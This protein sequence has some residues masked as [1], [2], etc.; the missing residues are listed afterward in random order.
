MTMQILAGEGLDKL[1][2]QR[3]E[4]P[5]SETVMAFLAQLSALLL[6]HPR[7]KAHPE[8]TALGFWLR[9]AHLSQLHSALPPL[10]SGLRKPLG[11][12]L[13]ITPAN[14]DSMFIYSWVCSLL[15]GNRNILRLSSQSSEVKDC[16]LDLLLELFEQSRFSDLKAGNLFVSYPKD[17]ATS[18]QL[19]LL[20]DA[21][22]IWGGDDTITAIRSLPCKPRCR[23]IPFADRYSA[24]LING[25]RLSDP[26]DVNKLA[27][28]LWR[29]TRPYDQ[30]AC[31]S[32]R[33]LLWTG[34]EANQQ[35]LFDAIGELAQQQDM[36]ISRCNNHLLNSQILQAQ[37]YSAAPAMLGSVSVIPV[38]T[39]SS[40]SLDWHP[41][42][43]LYYLLRLNQ[44]QSLPTILDSK[45]QTLSYWGYEQP[46]LLRFMA[47]M[48]IT[49]V[50]RIVPV[51]QAL[52]FSPQW[53]GYDLF[54]QLSRI[55]TLE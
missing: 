34:N 31:S 43:G 30:M 52:D 54:S 46:E 35:R 49:G 53:D 37:G 55:Q 32:P 19:S 26:Q 36:A 20:A 11:L 8:L 10:Q 2:A 3:P 7:A 16:L 13:H 17:D 6:K 42:Q 1:K 47:D 27:E 24:V 48:S 39:F 18:S 41:G 9:P 12:V 15:M 29:D 4:M 23:D 14:V 38:N 50:D 33:L 22:V 28:L 5:F 40:Q 51:G 45:C 21:R 25:D 44:P